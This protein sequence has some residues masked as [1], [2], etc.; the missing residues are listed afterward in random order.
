MAKFIWA[1]SLGHP[2]LLLPHGDLPF[3]GITAL[4]G[5]PGEV[6]LVIDDDVEGPA[7]NGWGL[8]FSLSFTEARALALDLLD[9]T[10][11]P[12]SGGQ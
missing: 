12:P 11:I 1:A 3:T 6:E 4:D 9:I 2:D 8:L 7:E 10:G 5:E